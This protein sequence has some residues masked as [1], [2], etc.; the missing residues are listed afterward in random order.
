MLRERAARYFGEDYNCAQCILKAAEEE[1][2]VE[3][4]GQ[5]Y[6]ALAAVSGGLGIGAACCA[7]VAGIMLFGL[8]ADESAAKSMRIRLLAEFS[9]L[10]SD[11]NCAALARG[12][13]CGRII[14]DIADIID[15][16][17]AGRA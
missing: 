12:G 6:P 17:M 1:Y 9:D 8:V 3:V 4:A 11:I 2:G 5:F 14:G 10:Y 15:G 7:L 13:D 16:I